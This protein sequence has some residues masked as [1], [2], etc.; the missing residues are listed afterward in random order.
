VGFDA[1][2]ATTR[3]GLGLVS[4]R[5]RVSSVDGELFLDSRPGA[6]TR[7]RASVPSKGRELTAAQTPA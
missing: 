7:V 3:Y 2:A 4:M 1:E 5:E 6:G